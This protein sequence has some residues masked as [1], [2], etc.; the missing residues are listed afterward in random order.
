ML[1]T[2]NL[3]FEQP[4]LNSGL[5]SA[6]KMRVGLYRKLQTMIAS[7]DTL[8]QAFGYEPGQICIRVFEGLRDLSTQ[9]MLFQKKLEEILVKNPHFAMEEAERETAKWVSPVKN[10]VPVHST[11]G[12]V[13]IRLWDDHRGE[14]LD[15]GIFGVIWGANET[16][17][18]F[19]ENISDE[20]KKNRLYCLLAAEQAGLTNYS[21]EFWHFSSK[22]R[23][24][25]YWT[26]ESEHASYGAIHENMNGLV[27]HKN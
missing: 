19:S 11:G 1:P 16:G 17:P 22:D 24:A 2:P 18:T 21:Y 4:F 8:S 3:P 12:A 13:D 10:N 9:N 25:I 7:L 26:K 6:S 14:F 5:P 23:Y 15:M 27:N 20:Q